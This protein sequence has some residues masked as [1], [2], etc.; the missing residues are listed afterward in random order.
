M[1]QGTLD[2]FSLDEVLGLLSGAK[3][4]GVLNVTGDRGIGSVAISDGM[5]VDGSVSAN[6]DAIALSEIVFELLRFEEGSFSF[7]GDTVVNGEPNELETVL[8]EAH[9][10]LEEWR[11]I[12][13]VVPSLDHHLSL[14]ETLP[15]P[16]VTIDES[17]WA[18]V[19]TSHG[20]RRS[21]ARRDQCGGRRLVLTFRIRSDDGPRTLD[22]SR[23][24]GVR[25]LVVRRTS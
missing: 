6:A 25:R 16:D 12:E 1:L 20:S 24:V 22:S 7:D 8:I 9:S 10:R 15:A 23:G 17:E 19:Q 11:G 21:F 4:T 14:A 5:L 3:K 18:A 2:V 13:A